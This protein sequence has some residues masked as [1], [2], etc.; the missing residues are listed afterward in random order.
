MLN[1]LKI[2]SVVNLHRKRYIILNLNIIN[3]FIEK[4]CK[5]LTFNKYFCISWKTLYKI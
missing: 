5:N 4:D 1:L 2:F 3:I